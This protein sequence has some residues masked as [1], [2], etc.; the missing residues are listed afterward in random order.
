MSEN[1][2]TAF[3]AC[4]GGK[5]T[6]KEFADRLRTRP[7]TVRASLSRAGHYLGLK[8]IKLPNGKLLWDTSSIDR[9]LSEGGL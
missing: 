3:C 8:P 1:A 9:L 7:Q 2:T 5:S 6:T 4:P